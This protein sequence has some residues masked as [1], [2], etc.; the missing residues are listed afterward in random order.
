MKN[1]KQNLL[2][3]VN[4]MKSDI[5][6]IKNNTKILWDIAKKDKVDLAMFALAITVSV[7][8]FVTDI[9]LMGGLAFLT[10]YISSL[11]FRMTVWKYKY[12]NK[13]EIN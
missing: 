13:E 9:N 12:T 8:D 6:G 3:L 2:T 5:K 4:T 1:I 7:L 10:V 11:I